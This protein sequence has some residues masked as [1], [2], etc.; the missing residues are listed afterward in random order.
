RDGLALEL[1]RVV[2]LLAAHLDRAVLVV[3][4]GVGA[5]VRLGALRVPVSPPGPAEGLVLGLPVGPVLEL[6]GRVFLELPDLLL[7]LL[8]RLLVLC[9]LV[10]FHVPA[11]TQGT[12][13]SCDYRHKERWPSATPA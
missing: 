4:D 12:A 13:R 8:H 5:Q 9:L 11:A 10:L 2:G 7:G 3:A 6:L 1:A